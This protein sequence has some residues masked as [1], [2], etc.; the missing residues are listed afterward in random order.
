MRCFLWLL[1]NTK[2]LESSIV[3]IGDGLAVCYKT[4]ENIVLPDVDLAEF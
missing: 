2:G 3:P 4:E 1:S